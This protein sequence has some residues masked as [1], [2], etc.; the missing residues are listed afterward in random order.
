M[1]SQYIPSAVRQMENRML[2]REHLYNPLLAQQA[3]QLSLTDKPETP[4]DKTP[5]LT[6]ADAKKLGNPPAF[7]SALLLDDTG[8]EVTHMVSLDAVTQPEAL[9]AA[10]ADLQGVRFV[11]PA[12][13]FSRLLGKYRS[14]AIR[15]LTLS[16]V[17]MTPLLIW[18]YG[19]WKG[20]WVMVPPLLA[21]ILAPALRGLAGGS[22]TFFDAMALVLV[23]SIG[24]DYAV[25][26]AESTEERK[27]V[28][29]LAVTMAACTALLSFGLLA[30][31]KVAAVH[32]FGATMT[33]GILLSFLFAPLARLASRERR[34]LS[35]RNIISVALVF[36]LCSCDTPS[37]EGAQQNK[38]GTV[39]I[40]PD[41]SLSMPT[42]ADLGRSVEVTQLVTAHYGD[43]TFAFEAHISAT[44]EHFLLV[45]LDL[46]GRKLMT[47]D[48]TK[49]K[50]FYETASWVPSQLHPENVLADIVLLYWPDAVVRKSLAMS[51]GK[52][53][54]RS[55][56]RTVLSRGKKVW[57]ATYQS[58]S[59][60]DPWSG[61]LNYSNLSWGYN[62]TVQ[63]TEQ[64]P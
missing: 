9:A 55:G 52:L 38:P 40:A 4:N 15:L 34:S 26:C 42:P 14:R 20:L 6:I 61:Q 8:G 5:P 64:T 36:I 49:D 21:V 59:K 28:T 2:Q 11:D 24:V 33:L 57:Q 3:V 12:S 19:F 47:I 22:F 32:N 53:V 45:G 51:G 41:L 63:S 10:A 56:V 18:R 27:S 7:L 25:F 16:A 54:I 39:Q 48:W 29:I 50:I 31:S 23:L 43:N 44:P 37:I 1:P 58:I 30:L 13:D 46:M 17:L 62:F 35:F 60:N